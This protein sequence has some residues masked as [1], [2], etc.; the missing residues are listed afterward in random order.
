LP[1]DEEFF[2]VI[3]MS[4]VIEHL[5]KDRL[6][7]VLQGLKRVLK[8]NGYVY[9]EFP[10]EK[11]G[12]LVRGETLRRYSFPANTFNFYDDATHISLYSVHEVIDISEKE[13]FRICG[14]GDVREPIKKILSP[15]LLL[16]GYMKRDE[17]VFTGALWST[18]NWASYVLVR[19]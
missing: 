6:S 15:L 12:S 8:R 11:T 13:G 16:L 19:K 14:Y 7:Y 10:S 4:H 17:S 3:I 18:V 5:P 9:L 2:D 1:F